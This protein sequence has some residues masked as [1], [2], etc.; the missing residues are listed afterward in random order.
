MNLDDDSD[1][2][3]DNADDDGSEDLQALAGTPLLSAPPQEL[4]LPHSAGLHQQ[5]F[6]P[7]LPVNP[8]P[9][10]PSSKSTGKSKPKSKPVTKKTSTQSISQVQQ[11]AVKYLRIIILCTSCRIRCH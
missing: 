3:A 9:P 11:D 8:P 2:D 10:P 6:G 1:D 4:P 5:P 7:S